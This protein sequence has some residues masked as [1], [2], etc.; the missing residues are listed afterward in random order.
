MG[1]W[2][3][4]YS[5]MDHFRPRSAINPRR[6]KVV[7]GTVFVVLCFLAVVTG[8]G[9]YLA[10]SYLIV[11]FAARAEVE[12]V[13]ETVSHEGYYKFKPGLFTNPRTGSRYQILPS[14]YRLTPGSEHCTA[15]EI[16]TLGE[17]S[18]MGLEVD[19]ELAWP[20]LL[21]SLGCTL[22]AGF[23]GTVSS[24]H[25]ALLKAEI[26]RISPKVLVYYGG[27]N[28]HG[29]GYGTERYPGPVLWPAGFSN[30]IRHYLVFKKIQLRMLQLRMLGS[31]PWDPIPWV[32]RWR[33]S[34]ESNLVEMV[35]AARNAGSCFVIAQQIMPFPE[36]AALLLQQGNYAAARASLSFAD[37]NWAELLRQIDVYEIQ[38]KVAH[39][40][41][42]P[43]IAVLD[44][45]VTENATFFLDVVHLTAAGNAHVAE[46]IR[47]RLPTACFN[48]QKRATGGA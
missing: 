20:A 1:R 7:E 23:L 19:D 4:D 14:G 45:P 17:S 30:W 3:G 15:Y 35:K 9:L 10:F 47:T 42:V 41:D 24:Q 28:D 36:R 26:A 16:V 38:A 18:T 13:A 12:M 43:R 40:L 48:G 6:G 37:R 2:T 8:Y 25:V 5:S 11:P 27:R 22:N 29:V 21:S 44:F 33:S 34:Y 31:D 32:N 46:R 39:D